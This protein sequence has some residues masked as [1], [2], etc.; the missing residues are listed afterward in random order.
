MRARGERNHGGKHSD[1]ELQLDTLLLY[2]IH[3]HKNHGGHLVYAS[4]YTDPF[5]PQYGS[6]LSKKIL[7]HKLIHLFSS[8]YIYYFLF[9]STSD[10]FF[11]IMN[12]KFWCT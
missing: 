6:N 9:V 2:A 7:G 1:D 10:P 8:I 3:G 5:C 4:A 12:L 11:K